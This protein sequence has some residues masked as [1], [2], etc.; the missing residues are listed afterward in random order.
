MLGK[1]SDSNLRYFEAISEN[2]RKENALRREESKIDDLKKKM[3]TKYWKDKIGVFD[4]MIRLNVK[5]PT[6]DCEHSGR[7]SSNSMTMGSVAIDSKLLSGRP[8][9][10]QKGSKGASR[11]EP[12]IN[13]EGTDAVC[14]PNKEAKRGRRVELNKQTLRRIEQCKTLEDNIASIRVQSARRDVA[15]VNFRNAAWL[16]AKRPKS[17]PRPSS[18]KSTKRPPFE[19]DG[20]VT[21]RPSTVA[22][23]YRRQG[24][25]TSSTEHRR[26]STSMTI[27]SRKT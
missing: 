18:K 8:V 4:E 10:L 11:V 27:R 23:S 14:Y 25:I 21:P 7:S 24:F 15:D 3:L 13:I 5:T 19:D 2:K 22:S 9:T 12:V 26:P 20:D 17:A 16:A 6:Y 1:L